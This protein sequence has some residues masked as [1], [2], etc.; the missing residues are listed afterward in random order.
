MRNIYV[1]DLKGLFKQIEELTV[2]V[3]DSLELAM[4]AF[5]YHD[6]ELAEKVVAMNQD[7]ADL[8]TSLEK[9]AYRLIALQQPVAEDLRY[10]FALMNTSVELSRISTHVTMIAKKVKRLPEGAMEKQALFDVLVTMHEVCRQMFEQILPAMEERNIEMASQIAR[11]DKKI[12]E[13]L[14]QL[15][16]SGVEM[17]TGDSETIEVGVMI[18]DVGTSIERIGDYLTN[19]CEHIIYLKTGQMMVLN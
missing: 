8:T 7:V 5:K 10:V 16:A 15:Y 14:N 2:F 4:T 3:K 13:Q 18:L 6:K 1:E 17:M 19:I 11:M 12:D 9:E